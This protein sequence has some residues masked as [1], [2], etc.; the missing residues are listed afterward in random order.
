MGYAGV[1][2]TATWQEVAVLGGVLMGMNSAGF[3][4]DSK[5][6]IVASNGSE[7]VKLFDTES[8]QE[9]FTL[10]AAGTGDQR[11]NRTRFSPDGKCIFWK[12]NSG[13]LYIW[14]A[15]S[16]DEISAAEARE[17]AEEPRR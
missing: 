1:W 4:P 3:S 15:P 10:G 8:W 14:R 12:N 2:D 7:A 6:L 9:V 16:W 11:G 5:R 13:D 17:K